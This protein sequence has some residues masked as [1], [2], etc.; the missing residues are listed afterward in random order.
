[1]NSDEERVWRSSDLTVVWTL[2]AGTRIPWPGLGMALVVG[3]GAEGVVVVEGLG[4]G[5][6]VEA[7]VDM[8][9]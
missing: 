9:R 5:V 1:L 8:L 7:E 6:E 3:L 2:L 4:V